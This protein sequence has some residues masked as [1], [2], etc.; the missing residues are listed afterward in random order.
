MPE[1]CPACSK[2]LVEPSSQRFCDDC[3]E[4]IN[5]DVDRA[6]VRRQASGFL[7]DSDRKLLLDTISGEHGHRSEYTITHVQE[8]ARQ[9]LIDFRI[10]GLWDAVEN[11]DVLLVEPEAGTDSDE[12]S[13]EIGLQLMASVSL[14]SIL[15]A[16]L[17]PHVT[18]LLIE[19][20]IQSETDLEDDA[21][22][23]VEFYVDG[24]QLNLPTEEMLEE[25]E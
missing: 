16:I 1:R 4:P 18:A 6:F 12:E 24:E 15:Y 19:N 17:G 21:E 22:I 8:R 7:T 25:F 14:M 13:N 9:A 10:V 3:G 11:D 5:V 20:A 2:S 23:E